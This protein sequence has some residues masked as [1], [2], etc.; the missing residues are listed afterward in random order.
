[1]IGLE[2]EDEED[3]DSIVQAYFH[4]EKWPCPRLI[5][6]RPQGKDLALVWFWVW[7]MN[8]KRAKIARHIDV[9]KIPKKFRCVTISSFILFVMID[10]SACRFIRV[11]VKAKFRCHDCKIGWTSHHAWILFDMREQ[12]VHRKYSN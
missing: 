7:F 9:N 4:F 1:M 3:Y 10:W 8:K 6:D 2:G 11:K 5:D 12:T